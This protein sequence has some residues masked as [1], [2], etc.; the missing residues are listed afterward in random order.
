MRG[1]GTS[2]V[3][4]F[5][6]LSL[7]LLTGCAGTGETGWSDAREAG[8]EAMIAC[9]R[10]TA[11]HACIVDEGERIARQWGWELAVEA[12]D[13][14]VMVQQKPTEHDLVHELGMRSELTPDQAAGTEVSRR[15]VGFLHG[16][17][18]WYFTNP[19]T[20]GEERAV[21]HTVC[22]AATHLDLGQDCAH[23]FGHAAYASKRAGFTEMAEVCD[24]ISR[25]ARITGTTGDPSEV[26]RG[27]CYAGLLMAFGPVNNGEVRTHGVVVRPSWKAATTLCA[28]A[29][30]AGGERCWPWVYWTYPSEEVDLARYEATCTASEH[31]RWCG[32]GVAMYTLFGS[33]E[34][35]DTTELMRTC[36]ALKSDETALGCAIEALALDAEGWWSNEQDPCD[37]NETR[38]L[39]QRARSILA[40]MPC[41]SDHD[42]E[43]VDRCLRR[44]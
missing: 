38:G 9:E 35:S 33:Q 15:A 14:Y 25:E 44:T 7:T 19:A 36:G 12:V 13:T 4:R 32:R 11:S 40:A 3:G 20:I 17:M 2:I 39:C 41:E 42:I 34:A 5:A 10:E 28:T 31:E 6:V 29:G 23:G 30:R 16:W 43:R 24:M 1:R 8:I 27:Q 26:V 21:Y 37:A 18:R 22:N